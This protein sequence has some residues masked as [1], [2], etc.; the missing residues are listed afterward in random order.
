[1]PGEEA[2]SPAGGARGDGGDVEGGIKFSNKKVC[3]W[4]LRGPWGGHATF[5]KEEAE[6]G[7]VDTN[8]RLLIL[9]VGLYF[10]HFHFSFVVFL[11]FTFLSCFLFLQ[12]SVSA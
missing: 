10:D 12:L 1:M 11:A 9:I 6:G 3:N 5:T 8:I 7:A 2:N 4:T